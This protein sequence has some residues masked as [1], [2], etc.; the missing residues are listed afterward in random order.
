MGYALCH[1]ACAGCHRIFG[2]NPLR[3]PSIVIKGSREPICLDCVERVN[4]IRIANGLEPIEPLPDAYE[5]IH[6][7][8]LRFD[9]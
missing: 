6:E 5:A 3:V 2:Y 7:S 9:D 4:P 8:E 1:S